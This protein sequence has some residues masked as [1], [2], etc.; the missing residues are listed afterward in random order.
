M[1]SLICS[2]CIHSFLC[3]QTFTN[4]RL[5][6]DNIFCNS[7]NDCHQRKG[8]FS[9]WD[10]SDHLPVCT[11]LSGTRSDEDGSSHTFQCI[12]NDKSTRTF[13]SLVQQAHRT[14]MFDSTD[15]NRAFE[16]FP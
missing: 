6:I 10:I 7:L 11:I 5:L 4:H 14:Q 1:A 15:A 12:I 3:I 8:G 13:V 16:G 9:Y 2:P